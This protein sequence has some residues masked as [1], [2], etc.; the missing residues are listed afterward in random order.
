MFNCMNASSSNA[1]RIGGTG[2][3]SSSPEPKAESKPKAKRSQLERVY[4]RVFVDMG[5]VRHF[6]LFRGVR[7]MQIN[8]LVKRLVF[9]KVL[10]NNR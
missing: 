7:Y 6:A 8:R 3:K 2:E 1:L 4:H 10:D 9:E 5:K